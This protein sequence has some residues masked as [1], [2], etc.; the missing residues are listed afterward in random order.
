MFSAGGFGD[1]YT[2]K[3]SSSTGGDANSNWGRYLEYLRSLPRA[4]RNG[5]D[6]LELAYV[7]LRHL[8]LR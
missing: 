2:M 6:L 1:F 4:N 3:R 5:A 8:L 7:S